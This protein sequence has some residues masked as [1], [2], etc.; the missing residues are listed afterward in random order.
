MNIDPSVETARIF[1]TSDDPE[2]IRSAFQHQ[3]EN[4]DTVKWP[5]ALQCFEN[6]SFLLGNHLTSFYFNSAAGFGIH[7]FGQGSSDENGYDALLAKSA[8]NQ[9]IGSVEGLQSMLTISEPEPRVKPKSDDP[10]D[11]D[12]ALVSEALIEEVWE[13]PLRMDQITADL[14]TLGAVCPYGA[15][16]IEYGDAGYPLTRPGT[17]VEKRLDFDTGEEFDAEI[18]DPDNPET[19]PAKDFVARLWSYFHLTADPQATNPEDMTWILRRSFVDKS[20]AQEMYD[21]K[22]GSHYT[23]ADLTHLEPQSARRAQESILYW[24]GRIQDILP[25]PHHYHSGGFS[26]SRLKYEGGMQKDQLSLSVLDVKPSNQFPRGR[27]LIFLEETMVWDGPARAWTEKYPWRWH[28]Y[29][30]WSWFRT[31]G[32]FD[33]VAMLTQLIPLQKKI[34]AIDA[35]THAWRQLTSLGQWMVPNHSNIPDGWFTGVPGLIVPYDDIPGMSKPERVQNQPLPQEFWME[36]NL[37]VQGIQRIS[38]TG[39][40]GDSSVAPSAL[41]TGA[42]MQHMERLRLQGKTPMMKG[43]QQC[44]E[45]CAQNILIEGQRHL[46][47]GDEELRARVIAAAQE[48]GVAAVENFID[49]GLRDHHAVRIDIISAQLNTPE[50]RKQTA[51][52]YFQASQGQLPP[53]EREAVMRDL[54][55]DKYAKS[56]EHESVKFARRFIGDLARGNINLP[57]GMI[58]PET[59]QDYLMLGIAKAGA[60]LPVFT[61]YA[62]SQR[63]HELEDKAKEALLAAIGLLRETVEME[64]QQALQWQAG[65]AKADG[66]GKP[67]QGAAPK[68]PPKK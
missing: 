2:E 48:K 63:F 64:M 13:R 58:Q 33:G 47:A 35:L 32:R 26:P 4:N 42:Q 11:I 65:L 62:L 50:A 8:D 55:L 54:Q 3:L 20:W 57:E 16:E 14:A 24:W 30:F 12:A 28:P 49:A 46:A 67:Q 61:N 66:A 5:L 22:S 17:K 21:G 37:L 1:Q 36:R 68:S 15:I 6:F 45:I 40:G 52:E 19:F 25:T 44:L 56:E 18:P 10:Y 34:N 53:H 31:P 7:Q 27:T 38:G 39:A 9:L 51:M 29:A 60:M 43:F 23:G 59:M 41:R